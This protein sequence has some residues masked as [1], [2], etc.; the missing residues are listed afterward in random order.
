MQR[1]G[2]YHVCLDFFPKFLI[3]FIHLKAGCSNNIP[4]FLHSPDFL[5]QIYVYQHETLMFFASCDFNH[6]CSMIKSLLASLETNEMGISNEWWVASLHQ[7]WQKKTV[8]I[9]SG[10][11]RKYVG[12]NAVLPWSTSSALILLL[13]VWKIQS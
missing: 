8:L 13:T 3:L 9:G 1:P 4:L 6:S 2:I 12:G 5:W 10:K 7:Y 11:F